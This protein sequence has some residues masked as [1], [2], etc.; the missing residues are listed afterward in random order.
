VTYLQ[1]PTW[2]C[3]VVDEAHRLKNKNSVL[4]QALSQ[5]KTKHRVLLTG[6]P[7][8]N[9]LSELFHLMQFIEPER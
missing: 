2:E 6:T 4:F 3:L 9:T 5:F 8:Q 7:L 1:R